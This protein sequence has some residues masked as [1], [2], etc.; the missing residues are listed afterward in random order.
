MPTP[1]PARTVVVR[2]KVRPEHLEAHEALVRGVFQALAS[3]RPPGFHYQVVK[4]GD[5]LS[6]QHVAAIAAGVP[7]PLR[8]LPA[9]RAF[10]EGIA[11]RCE[12]Q[13]ATE[14]VREIGCYAS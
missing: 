8:E 14:E 9:F 13:P 6:F 12:I 1:N 5:G 7:H 11:Q 10:Q 3:A 4:L 2:Y